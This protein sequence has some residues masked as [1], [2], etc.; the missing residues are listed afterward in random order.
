MK[1]A[2][3]NLYNFCIIHIFLKPKTLNEQMYNLLIGVMNMFKVSVKDSTWI[4]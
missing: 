1:L 3:E 4:A 2:G